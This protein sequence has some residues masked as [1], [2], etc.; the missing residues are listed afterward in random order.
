M[1]PIKRFQCWRRKYHNYFAN[2]TYAV[3]FLECAD[4]DK[5]RKHPAHAKKKWFRYW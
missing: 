2:Y 5:T 3:P 1:R 4:C